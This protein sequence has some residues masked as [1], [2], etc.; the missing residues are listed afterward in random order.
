MGESEIMG[1]IM[2]ESEASGVGSA[3]EGDDQASARMG[4]RWR[5]VRTP[6]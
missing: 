3:G 2:G 5:R 4:A 1:E 6:E